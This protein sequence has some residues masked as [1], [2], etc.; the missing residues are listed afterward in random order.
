[1]PRRGTRA[2]AFGAIATELDMHGMAHDVD[3]VCVHDN[4]VHIAHE[5]DHDGDGELN[6][7]EFVEAWHEAEDPVGPCF[8]H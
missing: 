1:M 2:E 8:H 3:F 7:D 6:L 5:H 4:L